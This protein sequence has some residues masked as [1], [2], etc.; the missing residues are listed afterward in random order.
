VLDDP[1]KAP[2]SAERSFTAARANE[3]W[4][5]D[6]TNWALADGTGVKILNVIDDH[7]RLA[8]AST[9]LTS[10]TGTAALKVFTDAAATVGWPARFLSDNAKAFRDVLATAVAQLG[11]A[12][13]HSRPYHP[14]TNGKVERFHLTLKRWLDRQSPAATIDELQTQLDLFRLVY[15]HHRPHRSIG[16]TFPADTW[17]A[18]P[19][20]GPASRPLGAPTEIHE[21]TIFDGRCHIGQRYDI[22]IGAAHNGQR[23]L[24]VITGTR[25]HVFINGTLVRALTLDPTRRRQPRYNRPGRPT[26]QP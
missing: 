1:R 7:S 20:T 2:K 18:A 10:C 5:L 15:N 21:A 3:C 13:G 16:K 22:T 14:Q 23:A 9:A 19:K 11:I 25:C 17:V 12:A 4:Q 24:A 8:V 6:D 26:H